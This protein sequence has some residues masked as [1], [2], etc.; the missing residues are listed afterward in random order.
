MI[1]L[2]EMASSETLK[3]LN[4]CRKAAAELEQEFRRREAAGEPPPPDLIERF[5]ALYAK[6]AEATE[7]AKAIVRGEILKACRRAGAPP[8]KPN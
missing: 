7:A 5:R 2:D 1:D 8:P 6:Q 4:E 3:T